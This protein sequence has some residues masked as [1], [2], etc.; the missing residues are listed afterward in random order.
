MLL[1]SGCGNSDSGAEITMT[2]QQLIDNQQYAKAAA[3]LESKSNKTDGDYMLLSSAYMGEAG[4]SFSEVLKIIADTGISSDTNNA[5]ANIYKAGANDDDNY[6]KFLEKIEAVLKD[7]PDALV[8]LQKAKDVLDNIT[9]KD[10]NVKFNEGLALTMKASSVFTCLGDVKALAKDAKVNETVKNDFRAYGCAIAKVYANKPSSK[11]SSVDVKSSTI[12]VDGKNYKL[13]DVTLSNGDGITYHKLASENGNDVILTTGICT[14]NSEYQKGC[15]KADDNVT[16]VPKLV[17]DGTITIESALVDTINDG[18]D[19]LIEIAPD[20][21]KDDI[22][23]YRSEI[24][25]NSDGKIT[26]EEVSAYIDT[27]IDE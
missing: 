9:N 10:D 14:S 15:V 22:R 6:V 7:K 25:T 24:D 16:L 3:L 11:C 19:T 23:D 5:P 13:I 12:A 2:A 20:D 4:F 8:Y 27:K 26:S 18:F 17:A 21:T 1:F